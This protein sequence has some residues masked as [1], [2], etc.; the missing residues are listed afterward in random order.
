MK[1]LKPYRI[2]ENIR[3]GTIVN[4]IMSGI[5]NSEIEDIL[6]PFSDKGLNVNINVNDNLIPS[7]IITIWSGK[8][9]EIYFGYSDIESDIEFLVNYLE[10][11]LGYKVSIFAL[12][13]EYSDPTPLDDM[14]KMKLIEQLN[15][16]VEK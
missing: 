11:E 16:Y 10:N 5:K 14:D 12:D 3:Y 8:Y 4:S 1:Y 9:N 15:I 6:I 13:H 7:V 2:F